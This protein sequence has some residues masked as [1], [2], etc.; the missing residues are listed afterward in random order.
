LA[1]CNTLPGPVDRAVCHQN[2]GIFL[3]RAG[4]LV[5]AA[6]HE[7]AALLYLL[8]MGHGQRLQTW[9]HPH[10]VRFRDA[11]QSG[12]EH[13]LPR[14]ADLLARPGFAPL[15]DWLTASLVDLEQL[16][17]AADAFVAQCREAAY[18]S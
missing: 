15:R 7:L 10:A 14:V 12:R 5:E 13:T 6:A 17:Q 11:R 2:L 9:A 16:Q 1:V 4:Q 8:V 3:E 18:V